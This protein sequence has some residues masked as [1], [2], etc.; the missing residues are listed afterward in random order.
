MNAKKSLP[1]GIIT[2]ELIL[3]R[4]KNLN[5]IIGLN[6]HME[7]EFKKDL[8]EAICCLVLWIIVRSY[9]NAYAP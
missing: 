5:V 4:Q 9:I 1:E 2:D 8:I 6:K 3:N 7:T